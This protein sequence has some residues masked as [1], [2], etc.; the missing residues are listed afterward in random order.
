MAIPPLV[1]VAGSEPY[2]WPFDGR[3]DPV[4]L[5][6]VVCGAQ[7]Q[8]VEASV[9]AAP[10]ASI[11][12]AASATVRRHRGLVI[13][14]RHGARAA[15]GRSPSW[16]PAINSV[17]WSLV[18]PPEPNDLVVDAAG[19]DGCY[20]SDLDHLLRATHRRQ[21]ALGGFASEV[22]V[23]S[24]VRALNDR[25]HECLVLHD[26]CAPLDPDLGSRALRSLTMSGGIFGAHGAS[27]D[28]A[29]ALINDVSREEQT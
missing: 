19:W 7:R 27:D 18:E 20:S 11:L 4:G 13:W 28:L 3:V 16:L 14:V 5:A 15:R 8:L 1:H 26:G 9:S 23:D 12:A 21:V 22:T 24:T 2:P 17:G 25:G 6:L 29:A 10:V